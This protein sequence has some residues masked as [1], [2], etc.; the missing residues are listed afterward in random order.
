VIE[1][2]DRLAFLDYLIGLLGTPTTPPR[3]FSPAL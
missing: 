1:S 2:V 3:R